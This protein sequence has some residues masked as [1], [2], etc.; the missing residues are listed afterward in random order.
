[1]SVIAKK[2]HNVPCLYNYTIYLCYS[3]NDEQIIIINLATKYDYIFKDLTVTQTLQLKT[4][5]NREYVYSF[6]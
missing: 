3:M 5:M 1:M 4:L 2:N 6:F